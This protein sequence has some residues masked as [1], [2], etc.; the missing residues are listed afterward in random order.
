MKQEKLH[1]FELTE[2]M[3]RK[4]KWH[5]RIL[6]IIYSSPKIFLFRFADAGAAKQKGAASGNEG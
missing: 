1:C 6:K 3:E 4:Q 2:N 5:S